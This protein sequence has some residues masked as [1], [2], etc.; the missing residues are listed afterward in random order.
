M[1]SHWLFLFLLVFLVSYPRVKKKTLCH[2]AF[3]LFSF[4]NCVVLALTF[5][6]LIHIILI[7]I[8]GIRVQLCSF[9]EDIHVPK[10]AFVKTLSF[11]L[12]T[13]LG[14]LVE[15]SPAHYTCEELFPGSL[16]DSI[17]LYVCLYVSTKLFWLPYLCSVFWN[18][19]V[20][21][22][23][24]LFYS[25]IVYVYSGSTESPYKCWHWFLCFSKKC[26]WDFGMDS[27][28]L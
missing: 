13:S 14:R 22:S 25:K 21:D 6:P 8:Y 4:R 24:S 9:H 27:S 11:S 18:L 15:R 19:E 5:R 20:W 17:G 12:L 23:P 7:L 16:F 10:P 3:F 26:H 2:N 28:E 1:H